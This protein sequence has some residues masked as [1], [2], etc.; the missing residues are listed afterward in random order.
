M[1]WC[2]YTMWW[3]RYMVCAAMR[4]RL[5]ARVRRGKGSNPGQHAEAAKVRTDYYKDLL[6]EH[7]AYYAPVNLTA[8]D[9]DPEEKRRQVL[10]GRKDRYAAL[11]GKSI[12]GAR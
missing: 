11:R 5:R 3:R 9:L 4:C 6:A 1:N 2:D 10:Q 7:R 12:Y 8:A